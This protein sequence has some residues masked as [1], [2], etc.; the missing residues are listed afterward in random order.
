MRKFFLFT[1]IAFSGCTDATEKSGLINSAEVCDISFNTTK[2][3][4]YQSITVKL[5]VEKVAS[6]EKTLK[7]L[8][9]THKGDD[10]VLNVTDD[11][12]ML[13]GDKGYISFE[14]INFDGV[15][16]LALTTSFGLA[17]LYLDYWV[18]NTKSNQYDYIGN[19]VKFKL[20]NKLMSLSNTVKI[21][22]AKYKNNTFIW[23]GFKL[24]NKD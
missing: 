15:P 6:D 19:H 3:C 20:N 22:A 18:Y 7:T 24:V 13:D 12:S 23:K 11:T 17:N 4:V 9:V 21:N 1:I 14:D 8:N 10:F 2:P 16:D 5:G